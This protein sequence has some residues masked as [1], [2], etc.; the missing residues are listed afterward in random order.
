MYPA[1]SH[2][3]F[4]VQFNANVSLFFTDS[5]CFVRVLKVFGIA[6]RRGEK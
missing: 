2:P 4:A 1:R 3:H 5:F 6:L